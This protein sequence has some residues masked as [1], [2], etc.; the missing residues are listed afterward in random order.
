M[1]DFEDVLNYSLEQRRRRAPKPS[2]SPGRLKAVPSA[3]TVPVA[4]PADEPLVAIQKQAC[5]RRLSPAGEVSALN[6]GGPDSEETH[7]GNGSS[8]F[9]APPSTARH[10]AVELE[11][12]EGP[13]AE[14]DPAAV[15]GASGGGNTSSPQKLQPVAP[16]PISTPA[17][18]TKGNMEQ[19][20]ASRELITPAAPNRRTTQAPA[21][22]P[23][24]YSEQWESG[25]TINLK[26]CATVP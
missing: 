23:S 4:V 6:N 17:T 15:K 21:S 14:V 12:A 16:L 25:I 18:I 5:K 1:H 2:P 11:T 7:N 3:L 8:Q 10:P 26:T 20:G 9:V 19:S 24:R 13:K 22:V